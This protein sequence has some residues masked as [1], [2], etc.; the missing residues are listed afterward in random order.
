MLKKIA[1][2]IVFMLLITFSAYSS[3]GITNNDKDTKVDFNDYLNLKKQT[4]GKSEISDYW[5]EQEKLI[6]TS[7]T[8]GDKFGNSV[9]IDGSYAIVGAYEDNNFTGSAYIFK[10]NGLIWIEEQKLTA[11]DGE[12]GDH[13]GCSVSIYENLVIVGAS[14]DDICTGSAYIFKRNGST[15]IEEQ[16]LIASDREEGDHFG[17]SVSI[18][19]NLAIIGAY[20]DNN[21]AGSAYAFNYSGSTWDELIKLTAP[22]GE[23]LDCFGCSVS[24]DGRFAIIGAY[25]DDLYF[26]SAYILEYCCYFK[27]REKVNILGGSPYFGWSVSIDGDYAIIGAPGLPLSGSPGSVYIFK[28]DENRWYE[29]AY[30]NGTNNDEYLGLSVTIDGGYAIAGAYGDDSGTGFAYTFNRNG[31]VWSEEQKLIA[32]DGE[33]G[34]H[35][36]CSVSI[37]AGYAIIGADGD[38]GNTG[39]AY[40]FMKTGIPDLSIEIIGGLGPKIIITNNGDNDTKNLDVDISIKGGIFKMVNKSL[41]Y[42]VDI[43]AGESKKIP[44]GLFFGFGKVYITATTDFKEKTVYALQ[45]LIYT[46]IQ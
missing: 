40:V 28:R 12:I 5:I 11:S 37:D 6:T 13:F 10:R 44:T 1:G 43:Q 4:I 19:E 14:C 22:D 17:C 8:P 9:S 23:Q 18:N 34:D 39:S 32:S 25:G 29:H 46:Y 2:F 35:F 33:E 24:Y 27:W 7:G 26:G 30:W 31:T 36:G 41:D 21:R 42:T 20:W 15:W 3:S 16:K 45:L 38:D